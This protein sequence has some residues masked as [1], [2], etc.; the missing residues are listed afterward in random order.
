MARNE[1]IIDFRLDIKYHINGTNFNVPDARFDYYSLF[2]DA[3]DKHI[4]IQSWIQTLS[5]KSFLI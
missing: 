2:S 1:R 4:W 3:R 5:N